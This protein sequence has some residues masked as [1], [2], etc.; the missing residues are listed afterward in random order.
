MDSNYSV[1]NSWVQRACEMRLTL[2]SIQQA[3]TL[4][5]RTE[6]RNFPRSV[7]RVTLNRSTAPAYS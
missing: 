2:I 7:R 3:T 4:K 5:M 1:F 6:P